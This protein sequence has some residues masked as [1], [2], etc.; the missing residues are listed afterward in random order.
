MPFC[1]KSFRIECVEDVLVM[2]RLYSR[3]VMSHD[4][5]VQWQREGLVNDSPVGASE[6]PQ[7]AH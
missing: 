1:F 6:C 2:S 3:S 5:L 7:L 4:E